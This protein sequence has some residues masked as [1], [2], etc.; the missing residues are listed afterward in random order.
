[1]EALAEEAGTVRMMFN[2]N[3]GSDAP[4]AAQQLRE[5]L[6]QEAAVR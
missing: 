1:V 6:G 2:N 5:L 4:V 3:R